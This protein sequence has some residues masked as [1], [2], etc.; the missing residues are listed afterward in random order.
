MPN[1]IETAARR[2]RDAQLRADAMARQA[3]GDALNAVR[4]GMESLPRLSL[5]ELSAV[6][7]APKASP[8]ALRGRVPPPP[9]PRPAGRAP[10]YPAA[11]AWPVEGR[12]DINRRRGE[13][14]Q[15]SGE[16]GNVRTHP[17]GAPKHHDGLDITSPVGAPA[18]SADAG[19]VIRADGRNV[20]GYGNQVIV[21]HPDG[22]RTR[23]A[24]LSQLG[25]KVGDR[26]AQR[27]PVGLTG[28]SGNASKKKGS[29]PHLHYEMYVD[30][31]PVDPSH[32]HDRAGRG[33]PLDPRTWNRIYGDG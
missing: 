12:Y 2:G 21:E 16:F 29:D 23:Y 9:V 10:D 28:V 11:L 19:R 5:N 3:Q 8:P 31:R 22:R 17:G 33:R 24:H 15:G 1:L 4:R 6:L 25:V 30:G 26:V 18:L 7:R 32:Y 13:V 20:G 27:Q 14:E